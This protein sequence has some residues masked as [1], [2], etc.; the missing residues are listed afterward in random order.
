MVATN[1]DK[2]GPYQVG[3][4]PTNAYFCN[5]QLCSLRTQV[6]VIINDNMKQVNYN[7][8]ASS[9]AV[10]SQTLTNQC[11]SEKLCNL[12]MFN[13]FSVFP[14]DKTGRGVTCYFSQSKVRP[15]LICP[16]HKTVTTFQKS[17]QGRL[18][19][20]LRVIKKNEKKIEEENFGDSR[21]IEKEKEEKN[22]TQNNLLI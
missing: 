13:M 15:C 17:L 9:Q 18:L 21:M 16:Q 3:L 2:T 12:G 14:C 20:V 5:E 8:G 11:C 19:S 4:L 7:S 6:D 1:H 22:I 10:L